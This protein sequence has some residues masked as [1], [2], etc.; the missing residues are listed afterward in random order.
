MRKIVFVAI[1]LTAITGC[2]TIEQPTSSIDPKRDFN[3]RVV[4]TT[5]NS[6]QDAEIVNPGSITTTRRNSIIQARLAELDILYNEYERQLSNDIRS[7]NFGFSLAQLLVGTAGT[8]SGASASQNL[9]AASAVLAGSQ[10]AYDRDI[11]LDQTLQAAVSQMRAN[12]NNIKTRILQRFSSSTTEYTLQMALSDLTAYE[13]AGSLSS[14]LASISEAAAD[15]RQ[16]SEATLEVAE[17]ELVV[18]RS[19]KTQNFRVHG[20][21]LAQYLTSG[22]FP[23]EQTER[24]SLLNDCYTRSVATS[25]STTLGEFIPTAD[26]NPTEVAEVI[27]CMK[28]R[29]QIHIVQ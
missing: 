28:S 5:L 20:R 26:S 21:G 14:A 2:A 16:V 24:F 9:S 29:Y 18:V 17:N 12:R 11:L 22:S 3:A 25:S 13:Q 6:L 4:N 19:V 10:A 8:L 27:S 7:G 23:V 1:S 15:Q